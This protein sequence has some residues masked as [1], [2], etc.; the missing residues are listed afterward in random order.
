MQPQH[1]DNLLRAARV[2]AAHSSAS[3]DPMDLAR[4]WVAI[5]EGQQELQAQIAAARVEA[6]AKAAPAP[7]APIVAQPAADSIQPGT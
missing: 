3:A 1:L 6:A 4:T 7:D 5:A 2:G